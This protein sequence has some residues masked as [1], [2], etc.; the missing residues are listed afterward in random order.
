V[1]LTSLSVK[2]YVG[3]VADGSPTLGGGSVCALAGSL[4]AALCLMVAHLTLG[5]ASRARPS[6]MIDPSGARP[7]ALREVRCEGRPACGA[8]S[9]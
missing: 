8:M 7:S 1:R 2:D 6:C 4:S 5:K 9:F 3:R